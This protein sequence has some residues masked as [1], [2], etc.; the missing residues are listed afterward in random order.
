MVELSRT[1]VNFFEK[2][3]IVL[4]STAD[5][6]GVINIAIK[7]IAKIESEG[8][9]YIIDLYDGNTRL[10]L[11]DNPNITIA[12]VNEE[13]FRGWQIKGIAK[14]HDSQ[15]TQKILEHWDKKIV[16]RISNRIIS[17]IKKKTKLDHSEIHLPKPKYIIEMKVTEIIDLS[18]KIHTGEIYEIKK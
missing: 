10:N 9:I 2:Q 15:E 1:V 3:Q 4:V 17:N 5:K 13:I 14:E 7:G 6:K 8:I 18:G 12:S 11:K 16:Q